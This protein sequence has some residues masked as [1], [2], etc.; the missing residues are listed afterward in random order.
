MSPLKRANWKEIAELVGIAAIVG[1][2]IFVG[3]QMRQEQSI[4]VVDTYGSIVESNGLALTLISA[5]PDIWERGLLGDDLTTSEE[6]IF[7]GVARAVFAHYMHMVIRWYRIGP[8]DP[9]RL[10]SEYAYAIYVFPG[11]RRLWEAEIEYRRRRDAARNISSE[12]NPFVSQINQNLGNLDR[13][14]PQ[15]PTERRLIFWFF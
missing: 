9:E 14:Q 11:L 10:A 12:L 6:T 8:E 7:S 2:L 1:S 3:L 13:E 4:A 5:H 15:I